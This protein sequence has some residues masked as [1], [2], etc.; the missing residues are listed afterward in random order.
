MQKN[1]RNQQLIK[2]LSYICHVLTTSVI[3]YRIMEKD[4][5]NNGIQINFNLAI[6]NSDTVDSNGS[7][8]K[9]YIVAYSGID[10]ENGRVL[11]RGLRKTA[12]SKIHPDY[13]TSNIKQQA[14]YQA[15]DIYVA[16]QNAKNIID[17]SS[18]RYSRTDDI[19]GPDGKYRVNDPLYDHVKID[20]LGNV[21]EDSGEQMKFLGNN[22]K[23]CFKKLYSTPKF[24]KYYDAGATITVPSDFYNEV[25]EEANNTIHDLEEGLRRYKAEGNISKAKELEGNIAKAKAIRDRLKDSGISNAEAIFAREHPTIFIAKEITGQAHKAG[26]EQLGFATA[27]GGTM[28]LINNLVDVIKGEKTPEEAGISLAKATATTAATSYATAFGGSVL[29][30]AMQ[31]SNKAVLRSISKTNFATH[32]VTSSI[33]MGK[34][35]I[36]FMNGNISGEQCLAELGENG[37]GQIS[38]ALYASLGQAVIPIPVV[39][40]VVGSIVGYSLNK[41]FYQQLRIALYEKRIAK[42]ERQRV[43]AECKNIILLMD[44]FEKEIDK[45]T[46]QYFHKMN[47]M[48]DTALYLIDNSGNDIDTF[49]KGANIIIKGLNGKPTFESKKEFETMLFSNKPDKF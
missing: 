6:L 18:I 5:D 36:S 28:S 34:S 10:N 29:K 32:A 49:I 24:Q 17:G 38:T 23:E 39:G 14:G 20:V 31:N 8:I 3:L 2:N 22:P 4:K 7:A 41:V 9:E 33:E 11:K 16:R 21:I 13:A 19:I 40:A 27:I 35:I 12:A 44:Q 47:T 1:D 26:M 48:F 42:E 25:K 37:T 43:E 30:G 45:L 15:E 46:S